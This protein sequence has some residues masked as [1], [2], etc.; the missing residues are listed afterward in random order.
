MYNT[1]VTRFVLAFVCRAVQ[2]RLLFQLQFI[3]F[4][5]VNII[6]LSLHYAYLYAPLGLITHTRLLALCHKHIFFSL[7][8]LKV[9]SY[10]ACRCSPENGMLC[11][12]FR[13]TRFMYIL[14]RHIRL[15]QASVDLHTLFSVSVKVL[16]LP[17][18][19]FALLIEPSAVMASWHYEPR[20]LSPSHCCSPLFI[21]QGKE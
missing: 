3:K 6:K 9:P 20:S 11:V 12:V 10:A 18:N 17:S 4:V 8:V 16:Q 19:L 13:I 14:A 7:F 1:R 21:T 5:N 15:Q 2:L